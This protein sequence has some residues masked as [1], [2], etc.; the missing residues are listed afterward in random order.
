V[1]YKEGSSFRRALEDRLR[2]QSQ[3]TGE[4]LTRL[5]KLV[6]FDRF[7]ARLV[8]SNP[9][10]W[11]LKGGYALQL[12]IGEKARTTKDI[13]L[14]IQH[15][16]VDAHDL[17]SSATSIDLEDWFSF[18]V[19]RATRAELG[20]QPGTSRYPVHSLLDGR[21][22]ERFHV[23]IGSGDPIVTAPEQL[24]GPPILEFADIKPTTFP[25]YPV[26][27]HLAEKIHAYTRRYGTRSS[28]RIRDL[29]DV[30]L[31]AMTSELNSDKLI[32]ALRLTFEARGTHEMPTQLA[33]PP[34]EWARAFPR[35][36]EDLE[37][38]WKDLDEAILAAKLFIEPVIQEKTTG[39][40]TPSEWKWF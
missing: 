25:S 11:V 12:R 6:A 39:I 3:S 1:K 31:I 15:T 29:V 40:W 19:G 5:R 4:P 18:E 16:V 7:L 22:F 14:S 38:P 30:L 20:D 35:L 33:D 21:T 24:T 34:T 27:Q 26:S 8:T 36:R 37:L 17:L 13:D 9:N 10:I 2:N 32:R 28:T 23:D